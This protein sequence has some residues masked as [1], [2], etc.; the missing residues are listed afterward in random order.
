MAME[1]TT[2]PLKS[3]NWIIDGIVFILPGAAIT[4]SFHLTESWVGGMFLFGWSMG[5]GSNGDRP[6]VILEHGKVMENLGNPKRGKF[7]GSPK[8]SLFQISSL[9]LGLGCGSSELPRV[10]LS[11][12]SIAPDV[13]VV[14]LSVAHRLLVTFHELLKL[15]SSLA[16]HQ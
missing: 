7:P 9:S 8:N 10:I 2:F 15:A 4:V 13:E 12:V 5:S 1:S 14:F 16:L 6:R 3:K 11:D